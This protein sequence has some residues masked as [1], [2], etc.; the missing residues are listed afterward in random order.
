MIVWKRILFMP[1]FYN[2][3]RNCKLLWIIEKRLGGYV[4]MYVCMYICMYVCTISCSSF[5]APFADV[6]WQFHHY[7]RFKISFTNQMLTNNNSRACLITSNARILPLTNFWVRTYTSHLIF[8]TILVIFYV[9]CCVNC[10]LLRI[11]VLT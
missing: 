5:F 2:S 10:Y 6:W 7:I 11:N 9:L 8:L 1:I 4:C 3:L